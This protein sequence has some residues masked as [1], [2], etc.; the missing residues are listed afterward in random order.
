MIFGQES[1][2]RPINRHISIDMFVFQNLRVYKQSTTLVED[3]DQGGVD[4]DGVD[5][6][7]VD[8]FR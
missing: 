2:Q 5:Q 4:R 8:I 1:L 6:G 7:E 3:A